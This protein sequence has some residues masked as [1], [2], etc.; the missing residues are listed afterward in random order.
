MS[1]TMDG[2][3]AMALSRRFMALPEDKSARFLEGMRRERI[4]P[5]ELPI[6]AAERA[7]PRVCAVSAAQQR[8]WF[9]WTLQPHSPAYTILRA[10]RVRG[11]LSREAL[12]KSFDEL[13]ARHEPLRTRFNL[14]QGQI[15]Q[16]IESPFA[17]D[18]QFTNATEA[19]VRELAAEEEGRPFDLRTGPLMRVYLAQLDAQDHVVLIALH[20]IVCD[21]WSMNILLREFIVAYDAYAAHTAPNLEPPHI[22]YAD[23]AAWQ[24]KLQAA[25]E[26]E[27][28]LDYWRKQLGEEHVVLDLPSDR[29]RPAQPTRIGATHH[30]SIEP[31]L[32]RAL[33]ALAQRH[34][35]TSFVL[36]LASFQV[37]LHRYSGSD[38]IRVGV[39]VAN[40][41]REDIEPLVGYFVNTQVLRGRIVPR[42]RFDELLE[43]VRTCALDAQSHQDIPFDQVVDALN[44]PR[45][46]AHSVL[47]QVA[48]N[49]QARNSGELRS[50]SGLVFQTFEYASRSNQFD[51]TL[52]TEDLT[53]E[54]QA[55]RA[56]FTYSA[57]LFDPF[58][59]ERMAAHFLCLLR[60]IVADPATLVADLSMLEANEFQRVLAAGSQVETIG[61]NTCLHAQL[62]ACVSRNGAATAVTFDGE[63]LSYAAL[64]DRSNQLAHRLVDLGVQPEA[65]VGICCERS[66]DLVVSILAVLK[67]GA[68][69]VPLDPSCPA[70]RLS[71]LIEDSG[72][73]WLLTHEAAAARLPRLGGVTALPLEEMN[74]AAA[75]AVNPEVPVHP[76]NLAYVIYT[77]GSTGQPKGAQLTHRNVA[78]LLE[79]TR[80]RFHFDAD[81]VWTLFHSYAFDFSVWEIFGCMCH[82]GR[83][84]IVPY[85]VSRAPEKFL[86]LLSA[87][88]VTV[89]NQTPSAFKQLMHI[90]DSAASAGL[91]LRVVIFG[92]EALQPEDLRPWMERFGD[93]R[94]SLVNMYG[95]TE[96]TVHVTCRPI[97]NIDLERARSPIGEPIPDLGLRVLDSRL[98]LS[99]VGVPGELYVSGAGLARGYLRRGAL[100]AERFVADPFSKSGER[101]YRT[102]DSARWNSDGELEYLGRIDQQVKLRG[103]RIELGEIESRLA[104]LAGIREAA[105]TICDCGPA[106][107][108]QLVAYVVCDVP[109]A[110]EDDFRSQIRSD[111]LQQLPDYMVP[112][113]YVLLDQMPLNANG[114]L[115][116]KALV[117]PD[118][119]KHEEHFV[120]PRSELEISLAAIWCDV[121]KVERIGLRS[122]FFAVG[123]SSLAATQTAARVKDALHIDVPIRDIFAATD[124][125][126]FAQRVKLRVAQSQAAEYPLLPAGRDAA[127]PLSHAQQR[128]WFLWKLDPTSAAFNVPA[129]VHLRGPLNERALRSA[130]NELVRRHE[131]LRTCFPEEGSV[132]RQR[133]RDTHDVDISCFDLSADA[134]GDR[135]MRVRALAEARALIPFDLERGALLRVALY[136]LSEQEHVL[137]VIVH[138]IIAD[139]RS[140]A[141]VVNELTELYASECLG[142]QPALPEIRLHYA[143]YAVWHRR[144]LESG[145]VAGQL[146][147]WKHQLGDSVTQLE[148]PADRPRSSTSRSRGAFHRARLDDSVAVKLRA[149]AQR[150]QITLFTLLLSACAATLRHR[151]GQSSFL[152]GTNVDNR[153]RPELEAVV[154]FFVNQLVLKI[155]FA[156]LT[157]AR[158]LCT[159]LQ[160]TLLE[161][162]EHQDLPFDRLVDALRPQ[163]RAG[164][165][166]FFNVKIIHQVAPAVPAT[167]AG[168]EAREFVMD[169][170]AV[171]QDL[172][173]EF[174]EAE[175]ALHFN[176]AYNCDLFDAATI[177]CIADQVVAVLVHVASHDEA[178]L[179][180]LD[181]IAAGVQRQ[182]YA[183][184]KMERS[185][186][187]QR[188]RPVSRRRSNDD[189]APATFQP[190]RTGSELLAVCTSPVNG[191]SLAAW[192]ATRGREIDAAVMRHGAILFR[193]F[194]VG[195]VPGFHQSVQ[196]LGGEALEYRNRS[197]PRTQIDPALRIYTSTE[198]PA[199]ER[200]FPHN[201]NSYA[202][203][204]PLKLFFYCDTPAQQGGETPIG[205]VRRVLRRVDPDVREQFHRRQVLYVRNFGE[206]FGLPWQQVFQTTDR[207]QVESYCASAGIAAEW[208][209]NG[210]LRT[211]R[212][213]PAIVRHPGTGELSW[214]N[215][216]TFFNSLTFPEHIRAVLTSA[217]APDELPQNTFYVDGAIIEP[218]V[219]AHLQ[220]A[221][222]EEML[223][224]T[225]QRGDVLLL[226]NLTTAHARNAFM[227]TRRILVGMAG[228]GRAAELEWQGSV[229]RYVDA[230]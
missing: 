147:Y 132:P 52:N 61:V 210:G 190:F 92:G 44:P 184:S 83:L 111:L 189:R 125:G 176:V 212:H 137:L 50:A 99:P 197:S 124:F 167:L 43:S 51:L 130:C 89:L 58:T 87:E 126:D 186:S 220:Q 12:Q 72:I 191:T 188:L 204:F 13:V 41:N 134:S 6:P 59:I 9:D 119:L 24:R 135:E 54:A 164:H 198:Y 140:M 22:Q 146:A 151:S 202:A 46:L 174:A 121:L 143:D 171:E 34:N 102:G 73:E 182:R 19:S 81:D 178:D 131:I 70:Q 196:V 25:G 142:T 68:A 64:N 206:G 224:F 47:F 144:W 79:A 122:N 113:H 88:R 194:D 104:E 33:R 48:H 116:R 177:A 26:Y 179:D 166:P 10:V 148:L 96:T 230:G 20:H 181:G 7:T 211:R 103:F 18:I 141:I 129:A 117:F 163:R 37:L 112:A 221:Y 145:P 2:A 115:D 168:L 65:R 227:G 49:H 138:H 80:E 155:E 53:A 77:S 1:S 97:K 95:I 229:E 30:F 120:G 162:L 106:R 100:T 149:L 173:L 200:I 159:R 85:E 139:A 153:P 29:P 62:E 91:V 31:S 76:D 226:D 133:V 71:Y 160:E 94:P 157:T 110:S 45:S 78:R 3:T 214:F 93:A 222:R 66:L 14:D 40:R 57:E 86:A 201:E 195:G 21:G 109:R 156:G 114:K 38:D 207:E 8:M 208:L 152:V 127:L 108:K 105:V 165:A 75:P 216:A 215:H 82:G 42:L 225:W 15:V 123:G 213:G 175:S 218:E 16:R 169:R 28:Q 228:V 84:V 35:T 128:L 98:N 27:R 217:Y 136:K 203:E 187:M 192:A 150:R 90:S 199:H 4:D 180:S 107:E 67:A 55:A 158:E 74:L 154:G 23:F 170:N 209:A 185:S 223:E 39:P 63:S 60:S 172:I 5:S 69:Y 118:T 17:V 183:L 36:L 193:G 161:A 219:I 101:L 32:S 205:D 56:S 11:K